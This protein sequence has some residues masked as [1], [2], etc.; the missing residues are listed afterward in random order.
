V[1]NTT[2]VIAID[3]DSAIGSEQAI[4]AKMATIAS[5]YERSGVTTYEW[6]TGY[7]WETVRA[8]D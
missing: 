2:T 6:A 8:E 4:S 1:P 3:S 7:R 5:D